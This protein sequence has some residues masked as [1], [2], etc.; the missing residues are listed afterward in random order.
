M[1]AGF[2][3]PLGASS[4]DHIRA[5]WSVR[6]RVAVR[7]LPTQPRGRHA[8]ETCRADRVRPRRRRLLWHWGRRARWSYFWLLPPGR[9]RPCGT[10]VIPPPN[11]HAEHGRTLAMKILYAA[12]KYDNGNPAQGHSFEHFNFFDSLLEMGH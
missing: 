1:D 2:L 9:A 3:G 10:E 5:G 8:H 6:D 7:R 4:V 11:R 12:T